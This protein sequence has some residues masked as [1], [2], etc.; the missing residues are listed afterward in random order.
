MMASF[1]S[2]FLGGRQSVRSQ[3]SG[4][5]TTRPKRANATLRGT[6]P[7]SQCRPDPASDLRISPTSAQ[8]TPSDSPPPFSD[9]VVRLV[10]AI[11]GAAVD[12]DGSLAPLRFGRV[13]LARSFKCAR[14]LDTEVAQYR[15]AWLCRVVVEKNVVAISPQV[16]LAA[17]ELPDLAQGRPPRR[18]NRAR[19]DLA[20][21]RGPLAGM[22]KL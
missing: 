22:N 15:R 3:I 5:P 16:W 21:H 12:G 17:N 19:R 1:I 11:V 13:H 10:H 6:R 9:R 7:S 20:P 4:R 8:R 2:S 18:A 14:D